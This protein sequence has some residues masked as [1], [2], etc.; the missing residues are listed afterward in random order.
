[1]SLSNNLLLINES[2]HNAAGKIPR[3]GDGSTL[4]IRKALIP[5][6]HTT[7]P[8]LLTLGVNE[9]GEILRLLREN[10]RL[11]SRAQK[12]P[13]DAPSSRYRILCLISS[14]ISTCISTRRK[15]PCI[16][17]A[18]RLERRQ[19]QTQCH[20]SMRFGTQHQRRSRSIQCG[21][22]R[23][24]TGKQ[25]FASKLKLG[26]KTQMSRTIPIYR[27]NGFLICTMIDRKKGRICSERTY[28]LRY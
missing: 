10:K 6:G 27:R 28:M 21:N 22:N 15:P 2:V 24:K 26:C 4:D 23:K 25:V 9:N 20:L 13:W 18:C 11:L 7:L 14:N 16:G 3:S 8:T 1:M 5:P 19:R 12:V 17:A